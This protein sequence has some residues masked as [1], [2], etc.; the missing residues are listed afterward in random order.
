[1]GWGIRPLEVDGDC[2][3][4]VPAT[5]QSAAQQPP[6][7]APLP[8]T[9]LRRRSRDHPRRIPAAP[10][11]SEGTSGRAE[12]TF[13]VSVQNARRSQ[14]HP[15]PPRASLGLTEGDLIISVGEQ[16]AMVTLAEHTIRFCMIIDLHERRTQ[17]RSPVPSPP[18]SPLSPT[19]CAGHWPGPGREMAHGDFI[20]ATAVLIH[21]A[22]SHP[23]GSV[24]HERNGPIRY[25]IPTAAIWLA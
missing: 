21:F 19:P 13:P 9:S 5:G 18:T 22:D 6:L 11:S 2:P 23:P 3:R 15:V 25:N 7:P 8:G 24:S 14:L 10:I 16:S 1:M 4:S 12:L 17:T 20:I